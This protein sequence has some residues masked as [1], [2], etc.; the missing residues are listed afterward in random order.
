M[1]D[2]G[3]RQA[4]A[5]E[6]T[7]KCKSSAVDFEFTFRVIDCD[8]NITWLGEHAVN[9]TAR[10]EREQT[11]PLQ[12]NQLFLDDPAITFTPVPPPD[13]RVSLI[14]IISLA[15]PGASLRR[16]QECDSTISIILGKRNA[17]WIEPSLVKGTL[18]HWKP[19]SDVL[20]VILRTAWGL[21][22][23]MA[24]PGTTLRVEKSVG[25][26][27]A[28][29]GSLGK[30]VMVCGQ[31]LKLDELGSFFGQII[32]EASETAG[33]ENGQQQD[34]SDQFY[35]YLGWW[36]VQ[37]T[38][39]VANISSFSTWNTFSQDVSEDG[40][41]EGLSAIHEAGIPVKTLL[42]D[43]GWQDVDEDRRLLSFNMVDHQSFFEDLNLSTSPLSATDLAVSYQAALNASLNFFT[44]VEWCMSHSLPVLQMFF[45]GPTTSPLPSRLLRT[46]E[47]FFPD[48]SESHS[49]HIF[50]NAINTS[51]LIP[52]MGAVL[53][54]WDMFRSTVPGASAQAL[55]RALSGGP[56][57]V[58]DAVGGHDAVVLRPLHLG[59]RVLRFR[60]SGRVISGVFG[61]GLLVVRAGAC[62]SGDVVGFFNLL[63]GGGAK[64][65]VKVAEDLGY[66]NGMVAV[67]YF[68][69]K[70]VGVAAT[71]TGRIFVEL[72][73]GDIE[74]VTVVPLVK[75]RASSSLACFGLID[76][77]NGVL[78]VKSLLADD[79]A[80]NTWALDFKFMGIFAQVKLQNLSD[81]K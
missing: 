2:A 58:S 45:V 12:F 55:A 80:A 53:P 56:V 42:I 68:F 17:Y 33:K 72:S 30:V 49:W 20:A 51:F 28:L 8:G 75:G 63:D 40:I 52:A 47:D 62:K 7:L 60:R 57:M 31:G 37:L 29:E 61:D 11:T 4:L 74:C 44:P 21:T 32:N 9:G 43:D 65:V 73:R 71:E 25:G 1:T 5:Y 16:A 6:L 24:C 34:T 3:V 13:P 19:S 46:S 48:I 26:I 70:A 76:K 10:L 50:S 14:G 67:R 18:A 77:Y 38:S 81:Y 78:A 69:A 35:D 59:G 64:A 15:G 41:L 23:I 22:M 54:D 39:N 79:D 36:Y 27:F 66:E